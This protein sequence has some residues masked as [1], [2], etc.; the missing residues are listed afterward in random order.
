MKGDKEEEF[1]VVE[2]YDDK[3]ADTVIYYDEEGEQH[4][5]VKDNNRRR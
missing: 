3:D 5:E 1:E 2:V 4:V